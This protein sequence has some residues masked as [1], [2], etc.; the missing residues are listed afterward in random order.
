MKTEP[1]VLIVILNWNQYESTREILSSLQEIDYQNV[2]IVLIDNGSTDDSLMR[3]KTEFPDLQTVAKA[4]NLGVA[5]GRNA[6]IAFARKR[7]YDYLLFLDN[8]VRVAPDFLTELIR[9]M[10][11]HS[12]AGGAQPLILHLQEPNR[13]FSAGGQF[14][15][16]ICHH[17]SRRKEKTRD[18]LND[19]RPIE[20]DWMSGGGQ[21]IRYEVFSS[22][23]GFDEDYYPYGCEDA[24]MGLDMKKA[25]YRILLAPGSRIWHPQKAGKSWM[26]FKTRNM[27]QSLVIFLRKN[28]SWVNFPLA[29]GWHLLNYVLRYF[30]KYLLTAQ[31]AQ[32]RALFGGIMSGWTKSISKK[33]PGV[34]LR[35]HDGSIEYS[36]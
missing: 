32:L 18:L 5:G 1:K 19:N 8:D 22:V 4:E 16:L 15:P 30:L 10:T 33:V 14:F 12:N 9:V 17:R 23:R 26:A 27:A 20:I 25:G 31:F 29:L 6:G 7:D 36:R 3:I 34:S 13:L 28:S 11:F 2:H 24:Q 35:D 21:L